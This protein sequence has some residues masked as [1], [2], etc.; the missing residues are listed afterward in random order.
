MARFPP[1]T[2]PPDGEELCYECDGARACSGCDG[3]G[4][5][6]GRRCG[7]CGGDGKCRVCRGWGTLP[8]GRLL[9][10]RWLSIA[11]DIR[12]ALSV[13]EERA[14]ELPD[15]GAFDPIVEGVRVEH[16][17]WTEGRV[18]LR[19]VPAPSSRRLVELCIG[20]GAR[21]ELVAAGTTREILAEI[22]RP[23][24]AKEIL[25]LLGPGIFVKR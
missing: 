12:R 23:S 8:A 5:A 15:L 22:A 20:D 6:D 4:R 3:E 2:D 19:V 25:A 1:V 10:V 9:E 24:K 18:E 21:T 7:P 14:R 11:H 13:V 17:K 16:P